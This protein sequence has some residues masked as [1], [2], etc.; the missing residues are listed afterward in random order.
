MARRIPISRSRVTAR[1]GRHNPIPAP[2]SRPV[3]RET[4]SQC[5]AAG[6]YE[7]DLRRWRD[8]YRFLVLGLRH[9]QDDITQSQPRDRAQCGEKQT[10]SAEL[11]EDTNPICAD[12][13]TNTDF[14]F[15][16]YGTCRTT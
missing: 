16:G 4:D 3:W 10:L 1:A 6:R 5:R 12:G 14:S 13:E 8:E 11:P 9:V 15:S 7:S 2:R